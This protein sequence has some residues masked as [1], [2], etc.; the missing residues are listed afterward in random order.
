MCVCFSV[1]V[2]CCHRAPLI[3]FFL[4][5]SSFVEV[6]S[7]ERQSGA[8]QV[9]FTVRVE[10]RDSVQPELFCCLYKDHHNMYSTMS[11]YLKIEG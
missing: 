2:L 7:Q 8:K 5:F 1:S 11:P 3:L 6:D 10:G 4:Y 9:L